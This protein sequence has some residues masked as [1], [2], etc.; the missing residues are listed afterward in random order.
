MG[1][2][3]TNRNNHPIFL[4][5]LTTI[6]VP[7]VCGVECWGKFVSVKVDRMWNDSDVF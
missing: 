3:T 6:L 1:T 2:T 4:L 7:Q 5:I